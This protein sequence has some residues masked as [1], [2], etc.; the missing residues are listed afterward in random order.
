L[1]TSNSIGDDNIEEQKYIKDKDC[2]YGIGYNSNGVYGSDACNSGNI[3]ALSKRIVI[4]GSAAAV[5]AG[6]VRCA[7]RAFQRLYRYYTSE[8][9]TI[10]NWH[11]YGGLWGTCTH[12]A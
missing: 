3:T 11:S 5:S 10:D 2:R 12:I 1:H 6:T 8:K 7:F 4:C 9:N